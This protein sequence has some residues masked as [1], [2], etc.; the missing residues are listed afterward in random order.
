ML[1]FS[2]FATIQQGKFSDRTER[3]KVAYG[4]EKV[5]P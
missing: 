4:K 2:Q 3:N 5:G 1:S